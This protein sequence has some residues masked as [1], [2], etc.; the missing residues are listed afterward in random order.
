MTAK[1]A[2]HS[3]VY[4]APLTPMQDDLTVDLDKYVAHC[5]A[6]LDAGCQGLMPLGST[7]EAHSLT[8]A[9][10]IAM[11]DAL[12]ESGLP[13]ERMLIGASALAYPDAIRLARHAV[14]IG[15]GGVCVQPPFYYKPAE[16][17]GLLE[18]FV[19]VIEGVGENALRV[20]VYDWESNLD[21]HFELEFF[22]RLFD[23]FPKNAVGIKDSSGIPAM[24]EE[25][26]RAFPDREVFAGTDGM[27]LTCLRAGGVG[28]MS[29]ISNIVP[30]V[31]TR[32][33][34][35]Y[36]GDVGDAM[37]ARIGEI[38]SAMGPLPW[39]SALKATMAWLS[40]D[41]AWRI[42]RPAIRPLTAAE[43]RTLF[44]NLAEIGVQPAHMAAAE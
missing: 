6:L 41:P 9:E 40:G 31:T 17:V 28:I 39:F 8:V 36:E 1:I 26:C 27:T 4:A 2:G 23:A 16:T 5:A 14:S 19:R 43:E 33:F 25:R 30:E 38:R 20:Y 7:G 10:R 24:L 13:T 21:V 42:A 18:F 29:G 34:A 12:A 15:A 22:H 44:H 11:M 37:Q 3:G 32:L 35:D